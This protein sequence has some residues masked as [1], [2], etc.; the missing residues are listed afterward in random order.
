MIQLDVLGAIELRRNGTPV[1]A[2]L[3]QPRRLA[4]L[5][6][7][8]IAR[9]HGFHSRDRLTGLFWPDVD[10]ERARGSLRQ[11][12]HQLR[13]ALGEDA[14]LARGEREVGIN[15]ELVRSDAA[16]FDDA[17]EAG[18][19]DEALACYRGELLPGFFLDGAVEIERFIESER[20][21]YRRAAVD[22]AWR[23]VSKEEA[24]GELGAAATHA[25]RALAWEPFD[26]AGLRRALPLVAAAGDRATALRLYDEFVRRLALDLEL[27]PSAETVRLVGRLRSGE[28]EPA[29]DRAVGSTP[30]PRAET[31]DQITAP[32]PVPVVPKPGR[33]RARWLG[34]GIGLGVAVVV[35]GLLWS[36]RRP[37]PAPESGEPEAVSSVAVLP[38]ANITGDPANEYLAD[39]I[40]EELMAAL[41]RIH[42]LKLAGH[43]SVFTFKGKDVALDSIGRALRVGHVLEGSVRVTGRRVRIVAALVD[44]R[45]GYH[46]WSD[47]YDGELDDVLSMQNQI[48][49]AIVVALRPRFGPAAEAAV[50]PDTVDPDA[51]TYLLRGLQ[52]LKVG[53]PDD[54]QAARR[55]F[56]RALELDSVYAEAYAGLAG[57]QMVEAL[58]GLTARAEGYARATRSAERALELDST[59][60][61][62]H[63][64][65]AR[66]A[67]DYWWDHEAAD[68]HYLRSIELSPGN[69]VMYRQRARLLAVLGRRDE[70]IALARQS[71][72]ID[73]LAPGSYR[74]LGLMQYYAG[75]HN[76]ALEAFGRALALSPDQVYTIA[77]RSYPLSAVGRHAEAVGSLERA[78]DRAPEDVVVIAAA[79]MAYAAAGDAAAA[80]RL[81][82]RLLGRPRPSPY[83][84]AEV[85][86]QLGE[87]AEMFTMLERAVA[88][89]DPLLTEVGAMPVFEAYRG[90]P[91]MGRLRTRINLPALPHP[92]P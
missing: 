39:G 4:L 56:E 76:E 42:G 53:G 3:V 84:A 9:P 72:E 44:V 75:R 12:L 37:T 33:P 73:P 7:L 5:A 26:E 45:S 58:T 43:T 14:I 80:R 81:L 79:A 67:Q 86:A 32:A 28:S 61:D 16:L 66:I 83:L 47:A 48:A 82:G 62:A 30:A 25:R 13:K 15:P 46:A 38:F 60:S 27:A 11:A 91:R 19:L 23:L 17:L 34:V 69:E 50:R 29:V 40:T 31:P 59:V 90:D 22:A 49:R 36:G 21:R 71:T 54:Y 63:G 57:V 8:A 18:R 68:R 51:H 85:L 78:L 77:Y 2:V 6:Y 88:E 10:Q 74:Y 41:A 35:A 70:A 87:R 55:F 52:A 1:R 89:R 65:L 20:E 92:A 64:V 24:R